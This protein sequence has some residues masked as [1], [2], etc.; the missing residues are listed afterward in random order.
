[1]MYFIVAELVGIITIVILITNHWRTQR[2]ARGF[3][4][5]IGSSE[6]FELCVCKIYCPSSAP[7]LIK[8]SNFYGKTLKIGRQLVCPVGIT[9]KVSMTTDAVHSDSEPL[10]T[11]PNLNCQLITC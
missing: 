11:S 10:N 8:S 2:G 6:F 3:T 7:I 4:P 1:M 9:E 5:P